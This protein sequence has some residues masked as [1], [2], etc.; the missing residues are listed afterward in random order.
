M[1]S[2]AGDPFTVSLSKQS[3]FHFETNVQRIVFFFTRTRLRSTVA[4]L[5]KIFFGHMVFMIIE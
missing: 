5:L 4:F 3:V 2:K 1:I